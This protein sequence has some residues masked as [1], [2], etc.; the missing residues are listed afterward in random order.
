MKK[1][2]LNF[3]NNPVLVIIVSLVIAG[4]IG[5]ISF[6]RNSTAPAYQYVVAAPG[7]VSISTDASASSSVQHLTL[8][9][10][11]SGRVDKVSVQVGDAVKKDQILATL[12]PENTLGAMT[13][14]KASY[15]AAVA[16]YQKVVNG[17]TGTAIDVSKA[18][19]ASAQSNLK[20]VTA[21]QDTL[22]ANARRK[23]YSDNLVAESEDK[24]RADFAPTISGIYNGTEAG[25]YHIYFEDFNMLHFNHVAFDGLE[26]GTTDKSVFPQPLGSSGLFVAFPD[27]AYVQQ[28]N[29]T[30]TIPNQSGANYTAN[31]NAYQSAQRT[32]YQ[33]IAAAQTALDQA[34]ANLALTAAQ[35]RP[36]DVAAAKANVESTQGALQMAQSAYDSKVIRAPGD[37]TVTAVRISEGEIAAANAPAIELSGTSFAKQVA[38][39]IPKSAVINRDGKTY[40]LVQTDGKAV[41][42]EITIG[43]SDDSNV[44]VVSGLSAGEQVAVQ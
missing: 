7:N 29:W 13:Q 11:S 21:Q 26:K 31:L 39:M 25:T 32:H 6:I 34:N 33:T 23:L 8:G 24:T 35:A 4:S 43:A 37:G 19:V 18:A 5:I 16:N 44:E 3:L 30:V 17:A 20:Q 41:E 12:D 42:K 15:D 1:P 22:V 40:A 36:E 10:L 27:L 9:F 38:V 2:L 14:A 28:D